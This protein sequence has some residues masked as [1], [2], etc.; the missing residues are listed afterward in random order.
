MQHVSTIHSMQQCVYYMT[1]F[2]E[3]GKLLVINDTFVRTLQ[4]NR[5]G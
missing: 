1:S 5:D 2:T 3:A 4:V